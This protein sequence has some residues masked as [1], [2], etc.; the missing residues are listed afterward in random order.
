MKCSHCGQ[1]DTRVVDSRDVDE[2]RAIRRR[3]ECSGCSARFTTYEEVEALK[4]VVAKRNGTREEYS[5]E[6]LRSGLTRAFE[7]RPNAEEYIEK[8]LG[9]IEYELHRQHE[10]EVPSRLIGKL[11]MSRL[12]V[13]DD[14]AYLRFASVYKSFGS[15]KSFR[16]EIEKLD[17]EEKRS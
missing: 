3:R 17:G 11:V 15:V 13:L 14:V 8:M 12:R 9:E 5:R 10:R 2:G 6:K 7:K 4:L 1:V 16:K